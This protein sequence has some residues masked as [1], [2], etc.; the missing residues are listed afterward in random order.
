MRSAR[1]VAEYLPGV[2]TYTRLVCPETPPRLQCVMNRQKLDNLPHSQQPLPILLRLLPLPL[3]HTY[4]LLPP[5]PSSLHHTLHLH[6]PNNTTPT[7]LNPQNL[8]PRFSIPITSI[9]NHGPP[10]PTQSLL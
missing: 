4:P 10:F 8:N 3:K 1:A 9:H 2:S 6:R 7:L 5:P